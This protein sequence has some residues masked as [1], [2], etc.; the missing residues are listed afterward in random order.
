M[1]SGEVTE[2]ELVFSSRV[3]QETLTKRQLFSQ[4]TLTINLL[5]TENSPKNG[6]KMKKPFV[7]LLA[8]LSVAAISGTVLVCACSTPEPAG[9]VQPALSAKSSSLPSPL[10]VAAWIVGLVAV[11]G[12]LLSLIL[13]R[14]RTSH[15]EPKRVGERF[16]AIDS[17]S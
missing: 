9:L 14:R 17:Y 7:A 3:S 4:E 2:S 10:I 11:F 6:G 12:A 5:T 1:Q 15:A 16:W 8:F 13:R